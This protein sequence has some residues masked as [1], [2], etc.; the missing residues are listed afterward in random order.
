MMKGLMGQCLNH[1][2]TLG[3][4]CDKARLIEDELIELK[5]WKVVTELKLKLAEQ[6][7]DEYYKLVEDLKKTLGDKE[8]EIC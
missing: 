1:K 6:A 7:R 5:N 3:R 2:T 4:V 8:N